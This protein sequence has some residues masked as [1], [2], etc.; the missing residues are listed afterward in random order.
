MFTQEV[1][2]PEWEIVFM[3]N[4]NECMMWEM[5]RFSITVGTSRPLI[6]RWR[7]NS[8]PSPPLSSQHHRRLGRQGLARRRDANGMSASAASESDTSHMLPGMCRSFRIVE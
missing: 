6:G 7:D 2:M 4:I 5:Q 1:G 3:F 8:P